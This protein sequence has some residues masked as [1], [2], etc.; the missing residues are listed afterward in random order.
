MMAA[1]CASVSD[2]PP[3]DCELEVFCGP[4]GSA[5]RVT[6]TA[7]RAEV[8]AAG[9]ST[10]DALDCIVYADAR[11]TDCAGSDPHDLSQ[12]SVSPADLVS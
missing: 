10:S 12:L 6:P 2:E 5:R 11:K 3:L 4:P 9:G 1:I 7:E 8:F